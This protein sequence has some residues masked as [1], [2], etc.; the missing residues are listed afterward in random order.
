[1]P[2]MEITQEVQR[3]ASA[4]QSVKPTPSRTPS[5]THYPLPQPSGPFLLIQSGLTEY[6]ILDIATKNSYPFDPPGADSHYNLSKN[7]SPTRRSIFFPESNNRISLVDLATGQILESHSPHEEEANFDL[8]LA[9]DEARSQL[10]ET[11][12]A[13]EALSAMIKNA[14]QKSRKDIR[15]YKDDN[16]W[17]LPIASNATS[18]NLS[19]YNLKTKALEKLESQPG[20]VLNYWINPGGEKVLIKK[21][22]ID[23]PLFWEGFSYFVLDINDQQINKLELPELSNNPS[24]FWLNSGAIGIIHQIMPVGGT[25]FSI[26]DLKNNELIQVIHGDFTHISLYNGNLFWIK[27]AQIEER[28]GVGIS[29]FQGE[30]LFEQTIEGRCAYKSKLNNLILINCETN[31]LILNKSLQSIPFGPLISLLVPAP[32]NKNA[33]LVTRKD[34]IF[35]INQDTL[36]KDPLLLK[37]VPLEIHWFPDG[38]GFLYRISGEL[39]I[40]DLESGQSTFL[41]AS[42]IFGDYSNINAMW[43]YIQ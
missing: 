18:T 8:D 24:L 4:T 12:Y 21:G 3:T 35:L 38:S 43:I 32:Q 11:Y 14:Y 42:E 23:E 2:K 10:E 40:Y 31:S 1:M 13:P 27:Y 25:D 39:F 26:L 20:L 19:L 15:W 5:F 34:G 16:Y 30:T 17:L 41:I 28:T 37:G 36:A 29:T 7:L 22:F 9:V 33:I 6:Q